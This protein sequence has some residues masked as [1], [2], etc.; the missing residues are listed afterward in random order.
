MR[1]WKAAWAAAAVA[2]ALGCGSDYGGGGSMGYGAPAPAQC[3]AANATAVTGAIGIAGMA[4][5]PACAKVAAGTSVTFT[6]GDAI[7]HTVTTDP[8]QAESFDSGSLAPGAQFTHTFATAGTV[9][10]HCTIHPN[11]RLTLFVQ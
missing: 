6:N 4:F 8:G 5:V 2:A 11:I 7:A 1:G 10:I 9:R 3:T